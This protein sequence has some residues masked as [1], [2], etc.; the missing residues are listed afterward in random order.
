VATANVSKPT[1]SATVTYDPTVTSLQAVIGVIEEAGFDIPDDFNRSG[2]GS[3]SGSFSKPKLREWIASGAGDVTKCGARDAGGGR[4]V[5]Q[6]A[7]TVVVHVA[8]MTCG[9]CEEWIR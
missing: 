8:G 1:D 3:G 4:A 6:E 5:V 9:Q 7:R 2:S